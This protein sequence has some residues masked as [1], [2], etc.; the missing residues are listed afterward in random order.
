MHKLFVCIAVVTT[1]CSANRPPPTFTVDMSLPPSTRWR[2]AIATVNALSNNTWASTWEPI[3]SNHNT[4]LFASVT[5]DQWTALGN[6]VKTHYPDHATELGSIASEFLL[7]HN[8]YVSFEYLCGWAYFHELAHSSAAAPGIDTKECTG[9]VAED[10]NGNVFHVANMDQSPEEVR[11]VTLHVEFVNDNELL[12]EAVDWYWFTTGLSRVVKKGV[13]SIQENWR[14]TYTIPI[15]TVMS[16]ITNGVV[17]Q[18]WVFR[19]AMMGQLKL[20]R[21]HHRHQHHHHQG[22]N[23]TVTRK[24]AA[25]AAAAD[26]DGSSMTVQPPSPLTYATLLQQMMQVRLAA[27]YYIV[28]AGAASGEGAVLARNQTTVEGPALVLDASKGVWSLAQTN[29]D[30]W[31]P[32]PTT[33]PRRTAAEQSLSVYGQHAAANMLGLFAIASEYPVHNPHTAYT[34]AMSAATGQLSAFVRVS[35]CP[36]NKEDVIPDGRYCLN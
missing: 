13:A 27:P 9:L 15:S 10:T 6:A 2:G 25:A 11:R 21:Y 5:A 31:Q 30:H 16:D 3:F 28:M 35:M 33:D 29:Y 32:D 34:A 1:I 12:F 18:I 24:D 20:P 8:E 36:E 14:T 22:S 7:V 19:H 26:V 4:T 17:P 23:T